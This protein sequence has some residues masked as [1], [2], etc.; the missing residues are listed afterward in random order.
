M[1]AELEADFESF[2]ADAGD[3][4]YRIA[5]AITRDAQMAGEAVG[6]ALTAAHSRWKRVSGHPE[7]YVRRM[8]LTEILGWTRGRT[9]PVRPHDAVPPRQ[10]VSG[11]LQL[12]DTDAVWAALADLPIGQRAVL[13]LRH[14]EH[15]SEDQIAQ[16]L[17]VRPDVVQAQ[18]A[19]ALA[20][21]RRL[22][23]I[24][25]RRTRA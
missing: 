9:T 13:V 3:R 2:V 1:K 22:L 14:Y 24:A 17:A 20:D 4:F 25:R 7:D 16:T 8:M 23:M 19:A 6:F 12:M 11:G 5:F 15:L 10:P 21:L 18:A